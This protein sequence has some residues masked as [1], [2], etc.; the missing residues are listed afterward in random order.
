M[1]R[2]TRCRLSVVVVGTL[3]GLSLIFTG[4]MM[5]DG[6]TLTQAALAAVVGTLWLGV[7]GLIVAQATGMTDI[8]PMSGMA[9]ISV[10]IMMFLFAG[11]IAAAM[12][13]GVAVS[14]AIGQGADMMQDLKTG[15][16]LGGKP[17]KQQ[18]AQFA[19][20]WLGVFIA[21]ATIYALWSGGTRRPGRVRPGHQ[22]AR[23]AGRRADG[24]YQ[25]CQNG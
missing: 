20:T 18:I 11:N 25:R 5:T 17:L 13:V 4:A 10:T 23:P 19:V 6:V 21:V 9:L 1:P 7:A 2:P 16:M 8:S 3:V 24:C 14:V 15:F 22:P 12:V